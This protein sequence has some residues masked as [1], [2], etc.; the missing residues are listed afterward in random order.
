MTL[1]GNYKKAREEFFKSKNAFKEA[2]K[3][4]KGKTYFA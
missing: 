1:R 3:E 4:F 2:K